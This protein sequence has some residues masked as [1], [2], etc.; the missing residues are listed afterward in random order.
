MAIGVSALLSAV[1]VLL[2]RH[3]PSTQAVS[4]KRA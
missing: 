1:I 4:P 2:M 3:A